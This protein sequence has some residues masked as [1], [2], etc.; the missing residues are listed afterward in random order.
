MPISKGYE[1]WPTEIKSS[2]DMASHI[3][4]GVMDREEDKIA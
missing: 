1:G 2:P 3:V 4:C